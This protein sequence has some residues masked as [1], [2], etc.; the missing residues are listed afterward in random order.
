MM[1]PDNDEPVGT[2]E[3]DEVI[4]PPRVPRSPDLPPPPDIQFSRPLP[5][6]NK[7]SA[8]PDSRP[9]TFIEGG[10]PKTDLGAIGKAGAGL[11][12]GLMF[13][14]SVVAGLLIGSWIE[15]RWPQTSPWALMIFTLIGVA[16][17]F[18][19]LFRLLNGG[20]SGGKS[21]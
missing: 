14:S 15:Q 5:E 4:K 19:T 21:K 16:S 10:A 1:E 18:L 17:G 11:S 2:N 6:R 9:S 7:T 3:G 8:N 13:G 20:D 12:A